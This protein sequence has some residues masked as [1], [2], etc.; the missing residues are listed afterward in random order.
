[1]LTRYTS[2]LALAVVAGHL[3]A[4]SALAQGLGLGGGVQPRAERNTPHSLDASV[5]LLQTHDS[6]APATLTAVDPLASASSGYSTM[7]LGSLD[8]RWKS[9]QKYFLASGATSVRRFSEFDD[10][11]SFSYVAAVSFGVD[12][13]RRNSIS[14]DQTAA[15][16]P[17]LYYGLFPR[18]VLQT[19]SEVV[20]SIPD[21][22]NQRTDSYD[23]TTRAAYQ[24][25]LTTRDRLDLSGDF[26]YNDYV[27]ESD[28]LRDAMSRG[29]RAGYTRSVSRNTALHA[30]YRYG[31]GTVSRTVTSA[32]GQGGDTTEH[33]V[34]VGFEY[35]PR[36]S[37][38]RRLYLSATVGW[39]GLEGP[40][41]VDNQLTRER[42]HR[43]F[44]DA[45]VSYPFNR[46]WHARASYNRNIEYLAQL[47][48]PVYVDGVTAVL[49]GNL[50]GGLRFAT[51][52]R[53]ARGESAFGQET[54]DFDT[55]AADV[56]LEYSFLRAL[57]LYGGYLYYYYDF[58]SGTI[59]SPELANGLERHGVRFGLTWSIAA[60]RR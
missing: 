25:A 16:V 60:V 42:V 32:F 2:C 31:L 55:Y 12:L 57:A 27:R 13:G 38:S 46:T 19:A 24:H 44:G 45:T 22:A 51:S 3:S 4:G 10:A 50:V 54:S 30:G 18:D 6:D 26:T 9:P 52:A 15:Y 39:S 11:R 58:R 41:L 5:S 48:R 8:Y 37:A 23:Y 35:S 53:Y 29:V 36:L 33:G 56:T 49:D 20:T 17:S 47:V 43:L 7:L 1:V 21:Y 40:T 34:D 59:L 28:S 14:I